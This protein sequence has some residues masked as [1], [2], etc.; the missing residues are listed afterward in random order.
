MGTARSGSTILEILLGCGAHCVGTGELTSIV[1]DGWLAN[2]ICSCGRYFGQCELW[3]RVASRLALSDK[4]IEE[5]AA[6]QKR[7]DWHTGFV[8]QA[9]RLIPRQDMESY[10]RFNSNLLSAIREE[11][12]ADV[13]IDSSKFAGRA[14]ALS[15]L[16]DIELCVICLT[17]S[18]EGLMAS[19]RKPNK[20]EQRPKAPWAV[21][22]YYATVVVLLRVA[23]VLLRKKIVFLRY[24]DLIGDGWRSLEKI[25][26]A[27]RVDF[28]APIERMKT[29]SD[30]EVGHIVTGNRL[31]KDG[32]VRFKTTEAGESRKAET[33]GLQVSLMRL[34][35]QLSGFR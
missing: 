16:P 7:I 13:I 31:R 28:S 1:K 17:R 21:F 23:S 18:P 8:A 11:S 33:H 20:D 35:A 24:E 29:N 9:F 30:F 10:Q 32:R 34:M 22:F 19:F 5:W 3:S 15:R 4:Q 25:G 27:F 26:Q 2:K 12:G 14:L 6:L